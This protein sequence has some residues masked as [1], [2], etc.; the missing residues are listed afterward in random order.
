[1]ERPQKGRYRQFWQFGSEL[2]GADTAAADAEVILLARDILSS[3]G[4]KFELHVG[5]LSFMRSLLRDLEPADQ[6]RVRA[7]L[8]KDEFEPLAEFLAGLGK[9]ELFGILKALV[10]CRSLPEAFALAGD[11]PE[12][13]RIEETFALLDAA[14]IPYLLDPGIA[15]GLDYY[16]GIVFE[17]FAEGLGAENQIMG[18][19]TYRLAHLFGG[20][21][22]PSCG[23]AIGFDR[24]MVALG[25]IQP[26]KECVVAICCT[27]EG[28]TRAFEVAREFRRAGI[29]TEM[30][31][32]NRG[33]GAQLTHAAKGASF[34]VVIGK[35][36]AES[37]TV[38]LKDLA[39]GVQRELPLMEA[40]HEVTGEKPACS[41]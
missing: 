26:P 2:I 37:G 39:T 13:A 1:Y 33:L 31:L 38:M 30:N 27:D 25:D 10:N 3:A 17:A 15:R 11:I 8:D 28:R 20:D 12:R 5:H 34:A 24:V 7:F 18:G 16:T 14:G 9:E 21:D 4:V 6:R 41:A 23:F 29:R 35:R 32:M 19:G 40:V 22:V 36:E